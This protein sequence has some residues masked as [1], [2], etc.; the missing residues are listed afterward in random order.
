[1]WTSRMPASDL[2]AFHA[3]S[4]GLGSRDR[5][6]DAQDADVEL[7]VVLAEFS[8]FREPHTT[9]A[10]KE[11][12]CPPL[13][14]NRLE[15]ERELLA[16]RHVV[17]AAL[18]RG[19][20]A[21]R[22]A[23]GLMLP[24]IGRELTPRSSSPPSRASR[25][26][27]ASYASRC[28]AVGPLAN[29]SEAVVPEAQAWVRSRPGGTRRRPAS[30]SPRGVGGSGPWF[31][32]AR[33]RPLTLR[34]LIHCSAHSP[35][36]GCR[37]RSAEAAASRRSNL[38]SAGGVQMP[39]AMRRRSSVSALMKFPRSEGSRSRNSPACRGGWWVLAK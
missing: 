22:T 27:P 1:M 13:G 35:K 26:G 29:G 37:L 23:N 8:C 33:G 5:P 3:D 16:G 25:C 6:R 39:A 34:P 9:P 14:S 24:T 10:G 32:G 7:D 12:K 11:Q 4:L 28:L 20:P 2:G 19:G 21:P 30:G 18:D 36:V 38:R 17:V 15:H 31:G